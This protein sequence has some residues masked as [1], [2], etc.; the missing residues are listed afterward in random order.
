[1]LNPL[2]HL[3]IRDE[4]DHELLLREPFFVLANIIRSA[5]TTWNM[6][7]NAIEEDINA[8]EQVNIDRLQAGMEQLRFN[9]SL[10][11]RIKGFATVSSYAIHNMGSRSWPAVTEPLLQRKLDLQAVLQIDFDEFKR[12]CAL[13]NTRCEKAMTILLTIAQLRQSQHATIQAYQVTDLSRLAFIFIPQSLLVS[14]FSM[15]I[16][17]LHRPPSVWIVITMAVPMIIVALG[18]IH[19]RKIRLWALQRRPLRNR[20]RPATEEEKI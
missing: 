11:D 20:R 7:L 14:A 6:M 10:I 9:N 15:N 17:E 16:A 4:L 12:R 18:L 8:C 3:E 13:F 5:V 2:R 19:R 1:M